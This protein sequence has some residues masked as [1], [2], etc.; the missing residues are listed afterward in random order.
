[1]LVNVLYFFEVGGA[2]GEGR[3][4][5]TRRYSF[6]A[7]WYSL[8]MVAGGPLAKERTPAKMPKETRTP[9][10]VYP[11]TFH[12]SPGGATARGPWAPKAI[13]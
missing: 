7:S 2:L 1:M 9:A 5:R 6:D 3:G 8:V 13:Q 10:S 4:E 12:P 11:R